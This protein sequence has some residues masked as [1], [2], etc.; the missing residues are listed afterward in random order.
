MQKRVDCIMNIDIKRS[1]PKEWILPFPELHSPAKSVAALSPDQTA[2][3]LDFNAKVQKGEIRFESV[4]CLCSN[5]KFILLASYDRFGLMQSTVMCSNC[6]LVQSNPRMTAKDTAL[7]YSSDVYRRI[8]NSAD[9]LEKS[10]AQYSPRTGSH[11]YNEIRKFIEI[12]PGISILEVGA[13]GGW[14]LIPFTRAGADV[15]GIDY[16]PSLVELGNAHGIPM[17][18]GTIEAVQ[19]HY[20]VIILSHV[21]EHL[22][23]PLSSLATLKMRL[24]PTGLLYIAVPNFRSFPL[25]DLQNAHAYYFDPQTFAH[26]CAKAG[27]LCIAQGPSETHHIFGIFKPS[28]TSNQPDINRYSRKV[29]RFIRYVR[30]KRQIRLGMD[31]IGIGKLPMKLYRKLA[32]KMD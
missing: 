20:D 19:G 4:P 15:V 10:E 31:S 6:G 16:S 29:L 27:L 7:F 25:N 32:L 13:G 24:K 23:D 22:P 2:A 17:K 5:R 28:E 26:Y 18:Q 21:L 1:T 9:Y 8:Y 3:V 14:N 12:R 30:I 11:I